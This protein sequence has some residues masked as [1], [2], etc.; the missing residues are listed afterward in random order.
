MSDPKPAEEHNPELE[1]LL[2]YIKRSRGF[3]L[4]AYKRTSLVRRLNK[5]LQATGMNSFAD[6]IDFLEVHPDE[7]SR[8][9]DTVLINV[10]NFFRD[11]SSWDYIR[12][13]IIPTLLEK[14]THDAQIRVWS[15]GCASGE[16]AYTLA[17]VL[18]EALGPVRFRERVKIY[19]SDVDDDALT[20][21]RQVTAIPPD[22]LEKYFDRVDHRYVFDKDLRRSVIFGRH[23]LIQDAPISRIDLLLCRNVLMY[24]NI[25]AQARVLSRFHFALRDSGF[26]F[27]G[28][29]E[30]LFTH[31]NLFRPYDLKRRVFTRV[32]RLSMRDRLL[33]MVTHPDEEVNVNMTKQTRFREAAFDASQVAQVVVDLN[34]FLVMVNERA[35]ALLGLGQRHV[36]RAIHDLDFSY[37]V[38]ELKPRLEIVLQERRASLLRET[39]WTT[40][41][42]DIH[43]LEIQVSPLLD[44]NAALLGASISFTDVS[45]YKRLQ[46]ELEHSN[47]ELETAYEEVQSTNEELE[48]TNEELQSTVE[49]LETTNEEL[50]STN[51]ELET[52]NEEL[53]STNEELQTIN[54]ELRRR[55]DELNDVN[56]FLESILTSMRG[57]VVVVDRNLAV[58]V[59]NQQS[60]D[61]WGLRADEVQGENFLNLD[62]GLPVQQ[63]R[64]PIRDCLAQA[65][66]SEAIT[67]DATNRRGKA[68]R[69]KVS[70]TPLLS[71][72][73]NEVRGV[74]LVV[75][76]ID[77]KNAD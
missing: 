62:I 56:A 60:E 24:F 1:T 52:M 72:G 11:T 64:Q 68:I 73:E 17:M 59:W 71:A 42:G 35:R 46:E 16:E 32:P 76:P 31:S 21:A 14:K 10:T 26:L 40:S 36:G 3:D 77:P 23:D 74:I 37:R 51:E 58:Q 49:E 55:T 6:Y 34:G 8:L 4:T 48:T 69:C 63:L 33:G 9:F 43:S 27:L 75:E 15:T 19:A 61:L 18:A 30:M 2:N 12:N 67:L 57:G 13:D 44:G 70:C 20:Q 45:R 28:K 38:P 50:Q 29:A 5:R 66:T 54:E 53:Q 41:S 7:F 25:D 22:L 65:E 39:E 47:Q